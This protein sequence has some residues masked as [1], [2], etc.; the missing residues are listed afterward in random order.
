MFLVSIINW[1]TSGR[2]IPCLSLVFTVM[3]IIS[4]KT[5]LYFWANILN[6]KSFASRG[7][8]LCIKNLKTNQPSKWNDS[9]PSKKKSLFGYLKKFMSIPKAHMATGVSLMY[10]ESKSFI[11]Y[12]LAIFPDCVVTT[13][14]WQISPN[15]I[16]ILLEAR[17]KKLLHFA[18]VISKQVK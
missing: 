6:L 10:L 2:I 16:F 14:H 5:I 9:L 11:S 18:P 1:I 17:T 15:I 7:K 12:V 3:A 13:T 4:L 8:F